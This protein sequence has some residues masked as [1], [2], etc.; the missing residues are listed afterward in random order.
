MNSK[1]FSLKI[2]ELKRNHPDISYMDAILKFCEENTID[3]LDVGK[4]IS[5]PLKEKIALEAQDLN[6]IE[7]TGKAEKI[8]LVTWFDD[9]SQKQET[10]NA[11]RVLHKSLIKYGIEFTYEFSETHHDRSIRTDDGW[12]IDIGRGLDIYKPPGSWYKVDAEDF[13]RRACFQTT[14]NIKNE[15]TES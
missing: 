11:F 5:K 13:E 7:K 6:L 15:K 4:L 10:E 14:I 8:Q 9:K 2:E 1:Q 3:P 12:I